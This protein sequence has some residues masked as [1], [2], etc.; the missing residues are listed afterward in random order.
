M[1]K[2]NDEG[3]LFARLDG[4]GVVALVRE[5]GSVLTRLSPQ[6]LDRLVNVWELTQDINDEAEQYRVA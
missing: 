4:G 3:D 5:D 2:L 1:F 6:E